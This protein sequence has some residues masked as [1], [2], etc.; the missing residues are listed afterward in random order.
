MVPIR[1]GRS[2]NKPSHGGG[3]R[4]A[5]EPENIHLVHADIE[6]QVD[7]GFSQIML[8]SDLQKQK[9]TKSASIQP[10]DITTIVVVT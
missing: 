4:S 5:M 9:H 8:W 1:P 10:E 3:D 2:S 6:Y 7:A